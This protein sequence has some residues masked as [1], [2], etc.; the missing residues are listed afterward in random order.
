MWREDNELGRRDRREWRCFLA[1]QKITQICI[2]LVSDLSLLYL[3]SVS[4]D[5]FN[6]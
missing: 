1:V 4:I 2:C 3:F 6:N 5:V